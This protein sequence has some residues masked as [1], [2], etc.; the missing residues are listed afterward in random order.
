MSTLGESCVKVLKALVSHGGLLCRRRGLETLFPKTGAMFGVML[1]LLMDHTNSSN[2]F[3]STCI[4]FKWV[5][6]PAP[7][8]YAIYHEMPRFHG[9]HLHPVFRRLCLSA[10]DLSR[11]STKTG[12]GSAFFVLEKASDVYLVNF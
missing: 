3:F 2:C 7:S 12:D 11:G 6:Q 5:V 10:E 4:F 9:L 8:D 1:D